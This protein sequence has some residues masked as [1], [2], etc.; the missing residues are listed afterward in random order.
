VFDIWL[1]TCSL[2]FYYH[3]MRVGYLHLRFT[4]YTVLSCWTKTLL[5]NF[6]N[7]LRWITFKVNQFHCFTPSVSI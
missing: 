1:K 2:K 4:V 3:K 6:S 7:A 5:L